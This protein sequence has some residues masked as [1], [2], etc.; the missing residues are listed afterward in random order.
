M[1]KA[2]NFITLLLFIILV[3]GCS[4]GDVTQLNGHID[5]TGSS[6]LFV[7]KQPLH[8]KYSAKEIIPVEPDNNGNFSLSVA[9]P[10]WE[11]VFFTI[12]DAAYPIILKPGHALEMTVQ[13]AH[14][15]DSV[16]VSGY[17][18]DWNQLYIQYREEEKLIMRSVSGEV[19]DFREG[20]PNDLLDL[21]KERIKVA[22][23]FLGD[24]PLDL[25]YHK[26]I[27]EYLV[28]RLQNI[29]YRREQPEFNPERERN[30]VIELAKEWDFFTYEVLRDQRAGIR[31]FTN[32]YAN[33][34]GVEKRIEQKYGQELMQYD[35]KRLGYETLDSA[36]TSVLKHIDQRKALA[37]AKM[38]LIAERIGEMSPKV[39]R[40]SYTA[41]RN[42]F[43]DFPTYTNF[44][45]H[46]YEEV[47][48]V[49]PGQPAVPF[50]LTSQYGKTVR[51]EDFRGSYVLLDFW[52]SWCIPCLDE[53][54]LMQKLYQEYSRD[55]FEIV[56]ISIE[57][58]S[59]K[60]RQA[61]QRF[62][63]PWIQLYGGNGFDQETFE[64]YKGGGIPFYVLVDREGNILRYNDIR[65]S[66]NL[67]SV[68]DSLITSGK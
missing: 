14:F 24:T 40:P 22:K 13:R 38:H 29:K 45:Q 26:A 2:I 3:Y 44:L 42:N 47:K 27:G 54:P 55:D 30:A 34:F 32:A 57:E 21:Y 18:Q 23:R 39:A 11:V 19:R 28:K 51:M 16:V 17:S 52:A 66:F 1:T 67:P 8:Y 9:G 25:Y 43:D 49:S 31:D 35:V 62:N 53:F 50:S 4:T 61:I 58:D 64:A 5:Y 12:D 7:E 56:G 41:Y 63:N 6:E 68:L 33:T 20:K 60:W 15:P 46:F 10:A 37:Y 59:L 65:P 48:S 36:R